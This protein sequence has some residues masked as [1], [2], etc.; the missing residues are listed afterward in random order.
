M[1]RL[2]TEQLAR[3]AE[4]ARD[5]SVEFIDREGNPMSPEEWIEAKTDPDYLL[6]A[7]DYIESLEIRTTWIGV[8]LDHPGFERVVFGTQVIYLHP[9]DIELLDGP[10]PVASDFMP[11]DPEAPFNVLAIDAPLVGEL[12][13]RTGWRSLSKAEIGHRVIADDFRK[14]LLER[15]T[16]G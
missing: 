14:R 2:S 10:L 15:R 6:V 12:I 5:L 3:F 1:P 4:R 16:N 8:H 9:E 11:A 7:A 13:S